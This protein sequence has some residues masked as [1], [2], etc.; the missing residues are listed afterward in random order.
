ML[1]CFSTISL[2]TYPVYLSNYK[3]LQQKDVDLFKDLIVINSG[4]TGKF[5]V[6]LG[7]GSGF[8]FFT[9]YSLGGEWPIKLVTEDFDKDGVLDL[10]I[11]YYKFPNSN[12]LSIF[13]GIG[14]GL[15]SV[16]INYSLSYWTCDILSGDFNN[17]DEIDLAAMTHNGWDATSYVDV[18]LGNGDGTFNPKITTQCPIHGCEGITSGFFNNDTNLDLAVISAKPSYITPLFGNGAGQ[19]TY[20]QS[21]YVGNGNYYLPI[22]TSDFDKDGFSDLACPINTDSTSLD[23]IVICFNDGY[24]NFSNNLIAYQAEC[25][26]TSLI[27][28][29]YNEDG[30]PDLAIGCSG[31][32][33]VLINNCSGGFIN[34]VFYPRPASGSWGDEIIVD[35]FNQDNHVDLVITN[36][37][38]NSISFFEGYGNGTFKP[39]KEY[40]SGYLSSGLV[41]GNFNPKFI[42]DLNS[43]GILNWAAIKP[44][45]IINGNFTVENI[46]HPL[47]YLNWEIDA[48]PDWGNW[49]FMPTDGFNLTPDGGPV[50]INVSVVVPNIENHVFTGQIKVVNI[51]NSSDYSMIPVLLETGY[52]REKL[53]CN[54]S[55]IWSDVTPL[56]TITGNFTVENI[57]AALSNL[58]WEISEWPNWG[59]WKFT[60]STGSHL[61][62]EDGP[63]IINV[64]VK[65]PLKRNSEFSGQIT[66][67]NSENISDYDTIPITLVTPYENHPIF[68]FLYALMARFPNAFP[69][70]RY[71]MGF[72]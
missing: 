9:N 14:G 49:T 62:P 47:S 29:D 28:G 30:F 5:S 3:S 60:P 52:Q 72:I 21:Y 71:L 69:L 12:K 15:F 38:S 25:N 50:I 2:S 37:I 17:D 61:T 26:P 8:S 32:I 34:P 57:G 56:A 55:L 70:L 11:P 18:L 53:F 46:G 16:A 67:V 7:N 13:L 68:D 58:S 23:K 1:F 10:A 35:D 4:E 24:G 19:F 33:L 20:N 59:V 63:V 39:Q 44:G 22:I 41:S 43:E 40:Y 27:S 31:N 36:Y 51:E 66:I 6:L 54:G 64:S 42:G 65:A 48:F 45:S